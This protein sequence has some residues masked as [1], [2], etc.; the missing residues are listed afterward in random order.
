MSDK[1][2]KKVEEQAKH[3]YEGAK[4]VLVKVACKPHRQQTEHGGQPHKTYRIPGQVLE[5][6]GEPVE[7]TVTEKEAEHLQLDKFLTVE[8]VG[9]AKEPHDSERHPVVTEA[10]STLPHLDEDGKPAAAQQLESDDKK[11]KG[12]KK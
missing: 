10:H 2:D 4:M 12:H 5:V 8:I 3:P 6:G 11:S 7:I 1:S 9:P